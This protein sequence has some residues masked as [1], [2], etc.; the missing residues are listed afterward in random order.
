MQSNNG[1]K[2]SFIGER[3]ARIMAY[4]K[5]VS[6]SEVRYYFSKF[7]EVPQ[8]YYMKPGSKIASSMSE[9]K[10]KFMDG[11]S[12]DEQLLMLAASTDSSNVTTMTTFNVST[13]LR[14]SGYSVEVIPKI[15]E[16]SS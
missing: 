3:N 4:A 6:T 16:G 5:N 15:E 14:A 10:K 8:K 2:A 7:T 11:L 12:L 1:M 13:T 9:E